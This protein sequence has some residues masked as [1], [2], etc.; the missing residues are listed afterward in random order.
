MFDTSV[1]E[2][3]SVCSSQ[4]FEFMTSLATANLPKSHFIHDT[5]LVH[6]GPPEEVYAPK[7][8]EETVE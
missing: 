5:W 1:K 8:V 7:R 6:T 3:I 2:K 4:H